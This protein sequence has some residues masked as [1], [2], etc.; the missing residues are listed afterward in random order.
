MSKIAMVLEPRRDYAAFHFHPSNRDLVQGH[1][2]RIAESIEDYY[3]LDLYPIA[4]TSIGTIVDGQNRFS[5]AKEMRI[6]FYA[7]PGDDLSISDVSLA[8]HNTR[9]YDRHDIVRVYS[10]IGL[11]PYAYLSDFLTANPH[12]PISTAARWMDT[13]Y[14]SACLADGRFSVRRPQYTNLAMSHVKDMAKIQPFIME[15]TYREVLASLVLR[16]GYDP[17]RMVERAACVPRRLVRCT[18]EI[19]VIGVLNEVYNFNMSK[20]RRQTLA[21]GGADAMLFD[22]EACPITSDLPTERRGL[23]HDKKVNVFVENDLSV[24]SVH[25][26]AR[27]LWPIESL[28][29]FMKDKNLLRY[30][31]I[32]VDKNKVVLDGQRRL[33]AAK[34]LNFPIYYIVAE[35]AS[36]WMV[37]Q[38]GTRTKNWSYNDYLKHFCVQERPDYLYFARL[39]KRYSFM[40]TSVMIKL[41]SSEKGWFPAISLYKTGRIDLSS[42]DHAE[43]LL[44]YCDRVFDTSLKASKVF[45]MSLDVIMTRYPEVVIDRVI[46]NINKSYNGEIPLSMHPFSDKES[47]L[48]RIQEIYNYRLHAGNV[49]RFDGAKP[50]GARYHHPII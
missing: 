44:S 49:V 6:P 25:S 39:R 50:E 41:L 27:R 2:E 16:P 7:I 28:V 18:R 1:T 20:D 11:A 12:V 13:R 4:T 34:K 45:Q 8:N 14:D 32:V 46:N 5:C 10:Q 9:A 17:V 23:I 29:D 15:S 26:S 19:E 42:K 40:Q 30:Y 21:L 22:K 3:L 37:S 43:M 38:A 31:P 33:A 47:C 35:N 48:Y 24:F 36:M